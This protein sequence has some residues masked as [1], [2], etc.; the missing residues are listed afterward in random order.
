VIPVCCSVVCAREFPHKVG[1]ILPTVPTTNAFSLLMLPAIL[2]PPPGKNANTV[3]LFQD[4]LKYGVD[5]HDGTQLMLSTWGQGLSKE[6][7][8]HLAENGRHIYNFMNAVLSPHER[9]VLAYRSD[10]TN[11]YVYNHICTF[12]CISIHICVVNTHKNLEKQEHIPKQREKGIIIVRQKNKKRGIP[13]VV[14]GLEKE[15]ERRGFFTITIKIIK[16]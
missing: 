11:M 16:T 6:Q 10:L 15:R 2:P 12:I 5:H 14:R 1:D 7:K 4:I 3:D 13:Q 9:D 8:K